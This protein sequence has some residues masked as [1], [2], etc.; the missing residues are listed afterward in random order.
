MV[1]NIH[2]PI[3]KLSI[4]ISEADRASLFEAF[5]RGSNVSNIQGT[6]LGLSIVKRCVDLHSGSIS[7]TS[8]IGVGTSFVVNL[9]IA[10]P[11]AC[12][13][14]V[15]TNLVCEQIDNKSFHELN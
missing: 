8:E 10:E 6:G 9:P 12:E 4:G 2:S 11:T 1:L 14:E 5:H 3:A 7:I 15:S 13:P